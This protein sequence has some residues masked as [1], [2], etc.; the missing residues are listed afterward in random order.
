MIHRR[1]HHER[2]NSGSD[3]TAGCQ[4]RWKRRCDVRRRA[5]VGPLEL[6][7]L[8]PQL[9][10]IVAAA[11]KAEPAGIVAAGNERIECG[12][13]RCACVATHGSIRG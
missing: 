5:T 13:V 3:A 6:V 11:W 2:Q 1:G 8:A 9:L 10:N 12:V 7:A 4:I